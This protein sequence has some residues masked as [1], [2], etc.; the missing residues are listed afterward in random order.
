MLKSTFKLLMMARHLSSLDLPSPTKRSI[1]GAYVRSIYLR[2]R[3]STGTLA[4]ICGYR[5]RFCTFHNFRLLFNEMFINQDY[6]FRSSTESPFILDCGSNIGMSVLY[7][8]FMYPSAEIV[9]FEPDP[10]A[11]ACLS[12]NVRENRLEGVRLVNKAVAGSDAPIKFYYDSQDPGSV[13]MSTRYERL[14]KQERTVDGVRL[15]SYIDRDVD[16]L[17]L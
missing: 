8:K 2:R 9:A 15:S 13:L 7:F 10:D 17:K 3:G 14:P 6:S 4:N 1:G 12:E 16:F 11:F 5:V